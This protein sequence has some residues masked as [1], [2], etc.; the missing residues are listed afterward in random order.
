M[1]TV[2][3]VGLMSSFRLL[4]H[5]FLDDVAL[6]SAVMTIV[7]GCYDDIWVEDARLVTLGAG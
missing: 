7:F 1:A 4:W 3:G 5:G 6:I 2:S